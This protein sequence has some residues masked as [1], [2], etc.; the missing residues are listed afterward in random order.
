MCGG[1]GGGEG[2][3]VELRVTLLHTK[4]RQPADVAS[5][6]ATATA[7]TSPEPWRERERERERELDFGKYRDK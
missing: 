7:A 3:P 4:G 1:W 2:G 6:V 5:S